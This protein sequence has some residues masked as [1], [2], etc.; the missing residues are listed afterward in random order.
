MEVSKNAICTEGYSHRYGIINLNGFLHPILLELTAVQRPSHISVLT[1]SR[2]HQI[3]YYRFNVHEGLSNIKL[4]EW[5]LKKRKLKGNRPEERTDVRKMWTFE[6]IEEVTRRYLK[7]INMN[8]CNTGD[9][10]LAV[11]EELRECAKI[12]VSYKLERERLKNNPTDLQDQQDKAPWAPGNPAD[13]DPEGI[14]P[15]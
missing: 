14:Q 12:L 15:T 10:E 11:E 4:D 1:R 8:E 13:I 2:L 3:P 5:K 9:P 6:Y 7:G